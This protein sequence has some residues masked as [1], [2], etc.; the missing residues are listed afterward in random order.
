MKYHSSQ[1][2]KRYSGHSDGRHNKIYTISEQ[3]KL[4]PTVKAKEIPWISAS[5]TLPS[6]NTIA[7]AV[8]NGVRWFDAEVRYAG[9]S[10]SASYT[11]VST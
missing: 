5:I 7:V 8:A 2:S 10:S 9:G 6:V 11:I 4:P 1:T 3:S